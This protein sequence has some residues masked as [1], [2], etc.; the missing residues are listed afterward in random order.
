MKSRLLC[1]A[2]SQMSAV[3]RE[4]RGVATVGDSSHSS[5]GCVLPLSRVAGEIGLVLSPGHYFE[6][7]LELMLFYRCNIVDF[8]EHCATVIASLKGL[9]QK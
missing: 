5:P 2:P 1:A 4:V 6:H 9:H 3:I 7:K 8:L